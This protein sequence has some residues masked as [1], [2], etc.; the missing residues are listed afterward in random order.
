MGH[1]STATRL[2]CPSLALL[3]EPRVFLGAEARFR[4]L[5]D[6]GHVPA[7]Y[8]RILRTAILYVRIPSCVDFETIHN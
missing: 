8:S 5:V 6:K 7:S 2:L 3:T 1:A 4:G